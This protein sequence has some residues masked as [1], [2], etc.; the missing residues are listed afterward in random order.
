MSAV[1]VDSVGWVL[2]LKVSHDGFRG[3]ES[4]DDAVV[5]DGEV[6]AGVS[7]PEEVG[8]GDEVVQG[9]IGEVGFDAGDAFFGGNDVSV[10]QEGELCGVTASA[11]P[12]VPKRWFA[13]H[14][15]EFSF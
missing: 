4:E 10:W 11:E 14:F 5:C 7:G 3:V 6:E 12:I 9:S 15:N 8:I 2:Y 13:H 1:V